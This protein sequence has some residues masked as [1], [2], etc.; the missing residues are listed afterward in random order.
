MV[1]G[2]PE[3]L[4]AVVDELTALLERAPDDI[5][6][7]VSTLSEFFEQYQQTARDERRTLLAEN[8]QPLA[9]ASERLNN[10]A[11]EECGLFLQRAEPTPIASSDPGIEVAPE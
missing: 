7:P 9:D 11:L 8:E 2:D 6:T 1:P 10:Y 4:D 3:R 5:I